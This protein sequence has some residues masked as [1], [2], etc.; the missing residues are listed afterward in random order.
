MSRAALVDPAFG[1]AIA[2]VRSGSRGSRAGLCG[3][4][5]APLPSPSRPPREAAALPAPSHYHG[6]ALAPQ[7]GGRAAAGW[8]VRPCLD[9]MAAAFLGALLLL[10]AAPRPGQRAWDPGGWRASGAAMNGDLR[11]GRGEAA[12][13]RGARRAAGG[14]GGPAWA[15][16][17]GGPEGWRRVSPGT[18]RSWDLV[19]Q[20]ESAG[21]G[22]SCYSFA[23]GGDSELLLLGF[24][25]LVKSEKEVLVKLLAQ[26]PQ[27][28]TMS[29]HCGLQCAI[30]GSQG[31][32]G[33]QLMP[34]V[35]PGN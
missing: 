12:E 5:Q 24:S 28:E 3:R 22:E 30:P 35:A 7:D 9:A 19:P 6:A 29:T 32:R 33:T 8:A 13:G 15:G 11:V 27:L 21:P 18:R 10:L 34:F 1:S 2:T 14:A 31:V 20:P 16:L 23:L 26:S 4:P 17:R 25:T